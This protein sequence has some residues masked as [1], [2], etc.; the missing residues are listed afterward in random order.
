MHPQNDIDKTVLIVQ[1]E[2]DHITCIDKSDNIIILLNQFLCLPIN[3]GSFDLYSESDNL[4]KDNYLLNE[5]NN[6]L[7]SEIEVLEYNIPV[8][9]LP[10]KSARK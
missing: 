9:P 4:L 6:N 10:P 2:I 1:D 8:T 7:L 5:S 3:Q